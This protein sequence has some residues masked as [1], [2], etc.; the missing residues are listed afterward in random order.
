MDSYYVYLHTDPETGEV[1]YVGKGIHGRAWDVTR[2]RNQRSGHVDWMKS[3][4][5]KGYLPT[6]WVS[7]IARGLP[8]KEAF[9]A[10]KEYLHANGALRFCG[11][12]GEKQHQSKMTNEQAREAFILAKN[13]MFHKDIAKKYGVG[14]STIAML[15]SGRQ[16]RAVTADLRG[17]A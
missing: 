16:W 17:A 10:E 2:A 5:S 1:T 8:E 9:K 4:G 12:S 3:L 13:G 7:I 14:R 6:D 15:A 11:M